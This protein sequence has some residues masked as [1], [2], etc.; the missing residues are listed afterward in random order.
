M[1]FKD[2]LKKFWFVGVVGILL[3]VF[4]GAYAANSIKN[5]E[6]TVNTLTKEG[7]NVIYSFNGDEYYFADDL[8]EDLYNSYGTSLGFLSYYHEMLDKI[9]PTTEELSTTAA[10][11]ASYIL[12]NEDPTTI[13]TYMKQAG[14]KGVDDL[15]AYCLGSL[16]YEQFMN[17]VYT[18]NYDDYIK[19][20]I[21][22][23]KPRY[24]QHILIS[25]ADVSEETD[26]DGNVTHTCNPTDEEKQKLN[27]ALD[28]LAKDDRPFGEVASEFSDDGSASSGGELG[29]VYESNKARYVKEFAEACMALNDGEISEPIQTQYGYH[30]I[31]A[32]NASTDELLADEEFK[33]IIDSYN[34]NLDIKLICEKA[35]EFNFDIKD[36]NI[37]A[38]LDQ[39][40]EAE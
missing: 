28:V 16:K 3:I 36:E 8:Y 13:D 39:Y 4:V 10:N 18:N 6:V 24:I 31:R 2:I 33:S 37:K 11:W 26:D 29:L 20:V 9:V 30:I 5:R 7:K 38:Y 15:T 35:K 40:L 25:V 23:E 19:P 32:E 12:Q 34:P 21:D 17:D 27:D 22:A 1:S 14:Y